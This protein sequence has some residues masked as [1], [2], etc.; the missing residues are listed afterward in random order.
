MIIEVN[1]HKFVF[2]KR[3]IINNQAVDHI[4]TEAFYIC[5]ECKESHAVSNLQYTDVC[6]EHIKKEL[7]YNY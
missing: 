6:I 4:T 1:G 7:N 3:T 5:T 2:S